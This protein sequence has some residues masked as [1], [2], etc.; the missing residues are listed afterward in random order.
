MEYEALAAIYDSHHVG[1]PSTPKAYTTNF[2]IPFL[3]LFLYTAFL[4]PSLWHIS[5]SPISFER[6]TINSFFLLP[7]LA[8]LLVL[9]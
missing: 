4:I 9:I 5:P 3:M 6:M 2:P 1:N 7:G 8:H